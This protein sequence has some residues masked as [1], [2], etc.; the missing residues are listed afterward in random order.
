MSA[1]SKISLSLSNTLST[2]P[3]R[4]VYKWNISLIMIF[5]LL[6]GSIIGLMSTT[7][8]QSMIGETSVLRESYQS[9]YNAKAGIE[10]G[11]LA[12][13]RHDYGYSDYLSGWSPIISNNLLN[14]QWNQN[15]NID[16][17]ITSRIAW[18]SG[19]ADTVTISTHGEIKFCD[20]SHAITLIP[21]W[22]WIMPLYIDQRTLNNIQQPT[23][24]YYQNMIDNDFSI[25]ITTP[26]QSDLNKKISYSLIL[27]W[28]T[29]RIYD[30]QD[31]DKQQVLSAKG[32]LSTII[33][34]NEI[35]KLFTPSST[36]IGWYTPETSLLSL[37]A[38]P[39]S[40]GTSG[41]YFNYFVITN[42]NNS[43][44][45]ICI[46]LNPRPRWYTTDT[47]LVTSI[48]RYKETSLWL[49]SMISEWLSQFIL[50]NQAGASETAWNDT[51]PTE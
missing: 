24:E 17:T 38:S 8:L 22:S 29:Q 50:A 44:I 49:Q 6:I 45:Q 21:W 18:G 42:I 16:L 28:W 39:Q 46:Q 36:A 14:T 13:A 37:L 15:G 9:Y 33:D 27:G 32:T 35:Q 34:N 20:Q 7:M 40:F 43:D 1:L 19:T 11:N 48:G 10:L 5:V 30:A 3:S 4:M 31:S 12:V 23:S 51:I 25:G 41:D 2:F 26:Q 47:S